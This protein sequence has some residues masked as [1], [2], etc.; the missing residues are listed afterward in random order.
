MSEALISLLDSTESPDAAVAAIASDPVLVEEVRQ[1]LPAL[2][3]VATA[4]AGEAG[5]KAVVGRRVALYPP[6]YRGEAEAAAWWLDYYDTLSDLSLASLEAG[7]RAYVALPD[8]EFMPKPG[9]LRELAFSAPCR[10]LTRLHRATLAIR[11]AECEPAA[12]PT[13]TELAEAAA[14]AEENRLAI[15]KM[16]GE[17]KAKSMPDA[18]SRKPELPSIAGAVDARGITAEMRDLMARRASQ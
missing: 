10:S 18:A 2:K 14:L 5:V 1:A 13:E 15:L 6:A 7:M 12:P 16:A 8:S 17:F 9:K 4:K 3:A 11:R